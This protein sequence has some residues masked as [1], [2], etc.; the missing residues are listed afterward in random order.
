[1]ESNKPLPNYHHNSIKIS[2]NNIY[3][4]NIKTLQQPYK[5][6]QNIIMVS[7]L[8]FKNNHDIGSGVFYDNDILDT[9]NTY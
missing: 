6:H 4:N 9:R 2:P 5:T 3:P 8:T 1:M 7:M